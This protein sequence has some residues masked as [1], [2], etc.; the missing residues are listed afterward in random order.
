MT[1]S[2]RQW[3]FYWALASCGV[4]GPSAIGLRVAATRATYQSEAHKQMNYYK[5]YPGDYARDTRH[6]TLVEHG[7]Y[8]LLLDAHYATER[9]LPQSVDKLRRIIGSRTRVEERALLSVLEE[10]W[11]LTDAGW[12]NSKAQQ[13]IESDRKRIDAAQANGKK[14]GRPMKPSGLL[15]GN[16]V[17]TQGE[18]SPAPAPTPVIKNPP[19]YS[20]PTAKQARPTLEQVADYCAERGRG[21]DAQAW[22]NHYTANG[23]RVGRNTMKD[24]K[25]AVRTWERNNYGGTGHAN[26]GTTSASRAKQLSDYVRDGLSG[27][28]DDQSEVGENDLGGPGSHVQISLVR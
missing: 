1:K 4:A 20:P 17:E 8:T 13:V 9:P 28:G 10:F 21:V 26:S 5:R 24:W 15:L 22:L 18:S 12:I 27:E 11:T 6:L 3:T 16:P 7:V 14:G 19:V 23:W 2:M 25:A